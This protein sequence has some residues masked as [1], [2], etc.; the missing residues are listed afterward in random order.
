MLQMLA[1]VPLK[2]VRRPAPPPETVRAEEHTF[3][4]FDA[5][6]RAFFED[7]RA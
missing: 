1:R 7:F 5:V 2:K 6:E 3:L 4:G